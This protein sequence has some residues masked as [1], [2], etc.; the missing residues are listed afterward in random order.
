MLKLK[1]GET[2]TDRYGYTH[3]DFVALIERY[4]ED[5]IRKGFEVV[6]NVYS[7]LDSYNTGFSPAHSKFYQ[8]DESGYDAAIVAIKNRIRNSDITLIDAIYVLVLSK[9][10]WANWEVA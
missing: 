2:F 9:P 6:L 1:S 5:P 3:G 8:I 7:S 10:L 4:T